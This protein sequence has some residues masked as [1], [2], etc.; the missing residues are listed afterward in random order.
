[1]GTNTALQRLS[2][3]IAMLNTW[4][5]RL[6]NPSPN[7]GWV[8]PHGAAYE[9]EEFV[10]DDEILRLERDAFD[11]RQRNWLYFNRQGMRGNNFQQ[12]NPRINHD[13]FTK[14]KFTIQSFEGAYDAERYLDWEMTVEQKFNTYLVS[15]VHRVRHVTTDVTMD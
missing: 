10:T 7:N 11:E 9:Q 15:E 5:D 4:F 1:M 13:P 2:E 3:S 12:H 14:V 6:V 8:D